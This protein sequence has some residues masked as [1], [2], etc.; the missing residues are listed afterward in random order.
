[1]P[2]RHLSED[3]ELASGYLS[4]ELWRVEWT[5]NTNL[6]IPSINRLCENGVDENTE[7]MSID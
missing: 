6:G 7:E 5:T 4:L 1:M 3:A 2:I